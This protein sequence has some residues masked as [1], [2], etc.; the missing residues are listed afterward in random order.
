MRVAGDARSNTPLHLTAPRDAIVD[1][2]VPQVSGR[3][4][5]RQLARPR[6][7]NNIYF[8]CRQCRVYVDAGYRHA[9]WELEEPK[10]V[11]RS[12]VVDAAAVL[13]ARA[14]WDV[15]ED[16]LAQLLPAVRRFLDVHGKHGVRL[17]DSEELGLPYR[18][19]EEWFDW[20]TEAGFVVEELPRYYAER[21]GF[22]TWE[23]VTTHVQ[24][25]KWPPSWWADED[26]REAARRKF[27]S[28]VGETQVPGTG[29]AV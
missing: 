24:S 2:R 8:A 4:F 1:A 9:Y 16:W 27:L 23:E 10:I 11:S 5:D 21:L 18:D 26:Q 7:M 6:C 29:P 19:S 3:P 17:G 14:Y 25:S 28:L 22:R 13:G 12:S 15:R 20:L